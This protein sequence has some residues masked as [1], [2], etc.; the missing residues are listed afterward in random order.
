MKT[1]RGCRGGGPVRGEQNCDRG[2]WGAGGR[3][4]RFTHRAPFQTK[5]TTGES[6]YSAR[7]NYLGRK[8]TGIRPSLQAMQARNAN[9]VVQPVSHP[10]GA[11]FD[12]VELHL[13]HAAV[14]NSQRFGGGLR[15]VDNASRNERA[16]V[17]DTNR[18]GLSRGDVGDAQARTEWQRAVSCC[19][20]AWN[21]LLAIRGK[22][23]FIVKTGDP[24][25][26]GRTFRGCDG[27][28]SAGL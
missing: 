10:H 6:L 9:T 5:S 2:G 4:C 21:E 16:A 15:Q 25:R 17:V 26:C 8:P 3:L 23:S 14:N 18:N 12:H 1:K 28:T 27:R 7:R 13:G 22:C 19:Q 11:L 20:F 24:M